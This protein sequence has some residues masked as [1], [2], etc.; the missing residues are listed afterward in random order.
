MTDTITQPLTGERIVFRK[1]ARDTGG[2]LLLGDIFVAPRGGIKPH[3]HPTMEES[4]RVLHGPITFRVDGVETTYGTG[5]EIVV[6]RGS[7]HEWWN[8]LATEEVAAEMAFRPA[9]DMETLFE[10]SF[11]LATDGKLDER[12]RPALL[13]GAV[14]LH[15]FR[16]E[17][18]LPGLE[19]K[20]LGV[21]AAILAPIGRLRGY[22][23]R[24][25]RYSGQAGAAAKKP[26]AIPVRPL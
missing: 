5:D 20:F 19:G 16:R 9:R 23:S 21:L 17:F 12:S 1:R 14:I 3:I 25:E 11:G 15:D 24:Y 4:F 18:A 13:Q 2:T 26:T 6:P 7:V 22:R 10:T 8:P